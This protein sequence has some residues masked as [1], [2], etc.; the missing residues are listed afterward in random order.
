MSEDE[1]D[2]TYEMLWNCSYCGTEKLLGLT[3][4]H[5]P[6]CGAAQDP[7]SRYFPDDA[8][9]VAVNDHVYVGADRS[10]S[11]CAA[12]AS[13]AAHFCPGCGCAMDGTAAVPRVE[14][15]APKPETTATPGRRPRLL[16]LGAAAALLCVVG[17]IGIVSLGKP[18]TLEVAR[19]SWSR[20]IEIERYGPQRE[21]QWC[22]QMSA[23]AYD[24]QRSREVKSHR[25]VPDGEECRTQREDLGD[26][27]YRQQRVCTPRYRKVPVY[28]E[29]CRYQV[30][31]WA[32]V[33]VVEARHERGEREPFWPEAHL[34]RPGTC[35]GCE[36]EGTRTQR[37]SLH[38]Q[39]EGDEV[40][41]DVEEGAWS[42]ARPGDVFEGEAGLVLS[43]VH[44]NSLTR[45]AGSRAVTGG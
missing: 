11:A 16:K 33:R 2:S 3:H 14:S 45:V 30:D 39:H 8:D 29:K 21:T 18:V 43:G 31:R 44:C 27:T 34:E 26:G 10:C 19:Q 24:V 6:A 40:A 5:C 22:T 42:A 15:G 37:Y 12:P 1:H 9:R 13:A 17:F 20:Q 25:K 32:A 41:C 7:G 28:A 36:R 4:R 23:G 35:K 38:F